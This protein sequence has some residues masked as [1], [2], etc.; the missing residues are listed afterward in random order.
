MLI[1]TEK[2]EISLTVFEINNMLILKQEKEKQIFL[3]I[4]SGL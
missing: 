4:I 3:N 2:N 1:K